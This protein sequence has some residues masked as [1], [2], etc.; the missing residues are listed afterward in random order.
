M[1]ANLAQGGLPMNSPIVRGAL[2]LLVLLIFTGCGKPKHQTHPVSG[3]VKFPD[4]KPLTSG[5]VEFASEEEKTKGMNARGVID[6]DGGFTMK[7][8][9][10]NKEVG[11]AVEGTHMV[12][13]LPSASS[14]ARGEGESTPK[15]PF[16]ERFSKYGESGLTFKVVPG[17]ANTYEIVVERPEPE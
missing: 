9:I 14:G 3:T 12:V 2:L 4:G 11:G 13:V 5:F 8:Y 16:H 15:A 7:T 17:Q 6:S 1:I 10:D